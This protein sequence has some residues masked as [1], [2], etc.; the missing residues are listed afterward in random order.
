MAIRVTQEQT[1][2]NWGEKSFWQTLGRSFVKIC[3]PVPFNNMRTPAY[4]IFSR[5]YMERRV[6]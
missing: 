3:Q 6:P 5:A 4:I 1:G 2:G